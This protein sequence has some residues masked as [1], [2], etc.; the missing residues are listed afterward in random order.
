MGDFNVVA[1]S[2]ER[3]GSFDATAAAEFRKCLFN[4]NMKDLITRGAWFTWSNRRGGGGA[5][6]SR[7]DRVVVNAAWMDAFPEAEA[8]AHYPVVCCKKPF[9]FFNFWMKHHKFKSLVSDSWVQPVSGSAMLRLSL[10]LKRL[11][12][13]LWDLNANCFSNISGR[14][15]D[16]RQTME[17]LQD[18]C[19][20]NIGDDNLRFQEKEA[21]RVF[22]E[23][24]VAEE[25]FKKQK[26]RCGWKSQKRSRLRFLQ[27]YKGLLGTRFMHKQDAKACLQQVIKKKVPISLHEELI[28]SVTV[29]EIQNALRSIKGDKAPSPDGYCSSFFQQNWEIVG[30]DLVDAVLLFF[31]KEFLLREWNSIALTLVPKTPSPSSVKD[32]RPIACCNLAYKVISKILA[33]R[34]QGTLDHVISSAQSAF[35]KRKSIVDNVLLMHELIRN[36]HRDEGPP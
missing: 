9:R 7:I 2:S 26:S 25:S 11:K 28:K 5:N 14:V 23:L 13:V 10:K 1:R 4:I 17:T 34:M 6:M 18:L 24:S 22:M 35:V 36:Y 16:A 29:E 33:K 31:E 3:V 19:N 32:Y 8:L 30:Q 15:G 21:V 12:P 20:Q 27:F